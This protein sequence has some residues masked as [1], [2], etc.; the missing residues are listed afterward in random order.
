MKFQSKPKVV[1]DVGVESRFKKVG[2]RRT[3]AKEIVKLVGI[4]WDWCKLR[5]TVGNWGQLSN[6]GRTTELY[7]LLKVSHSGDQLWPTKWLFR[8]KVS[9]CVKETID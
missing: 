8:G 1:C 2:L 3:C 5:A 7:I 6:T 9:H 4:D